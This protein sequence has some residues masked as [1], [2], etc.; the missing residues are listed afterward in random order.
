[1]FIVTEY[2]AL[3]KIIDLLIQSDIIS[4]VTSLAKDIAQKYT[5][6]LKDANEI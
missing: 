4:L 5:P 3:N 2:A 6:T 1:M